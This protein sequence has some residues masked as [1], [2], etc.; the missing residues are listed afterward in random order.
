MTTP[1]SRTQVSKVEWIDA[2]VSVDGSPADLPI[3]TSYGVILYRDKQVLRICSLFGEDN[4]PRV[5]MAIPASLIK[6][7]VSLRR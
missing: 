2:R 3:M 5:V 7:I 4:E 6:K 1:R